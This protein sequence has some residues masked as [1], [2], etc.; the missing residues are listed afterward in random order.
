MKMLSDIRQRIQFLLQIA[1]RKLTVPE[2][3]NVT[4]NGSGS[5]YPALWLLEKDG[6]VQSEWEQKGGA[7]P[8]RRVYWTTKTEKEG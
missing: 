3:C 6:L 2:I 8:R 4:G 5:A 1:N 7:Y